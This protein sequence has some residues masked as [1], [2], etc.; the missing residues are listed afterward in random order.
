MG[1]HKPVSII[2]LTWNGLD[3]TKACLASIRER[4]Q[5]F[6]DYKIIVADNGSTDGTVEYLSK[7]DRAYRCSESVKISDSRKENNVA[8]RE[9][10]SGIGC[11]SIE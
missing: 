1:A 8:I 6:K 5:I 4:R 3:Y 7:T 11:H 2:V 9:R 10:R